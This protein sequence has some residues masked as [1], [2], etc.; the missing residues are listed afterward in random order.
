VADRQWIAEGDGSDLRRP[1]ELSLAQRRESARIRREQRSA[2]RL[3]RRRTACL[4][5]ARDA[6]AAA[7]CLER[8][9]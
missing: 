6:Q 2:Q 1:G 8:F 7:R 4:Q 5:R 3:V 9:Q